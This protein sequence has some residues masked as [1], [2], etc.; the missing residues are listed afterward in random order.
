MG[1]AQG[2]LKEGLIAGLRYRIEELLGFGETG[3][4]YACR[5][6][7]GDKS[8]LVIKILSPI[9][10]VSERTE[11]LGREFALMRRLRHPN[12]VRILD[13]GIMENSRE[14]FLIEERVD[15]PD[16]YSG[17][18]GMDFDE[19]LFFCVEILKA[20]QYLHA[21][22]I[23]HGSL[24]PSNV[25]L[26]DVDAACR[27]PRLMDFNLRFR[28][29][30][31]C[32]QDGLR[33]LSYM[34]PE[35]LLGERAEKAS[36]IYAVGILIYQLLVRRLPFEDEDRGFLIQKQLQGNVDMKPFERLKAGGHLSLLI[37]RM[38][39]KDPM[40]RINSGNEVIAFLE[41]EIMPNFQNNEV[42]EL[43][44]HFSAAPLTGREMEMQAL[45][46]SVERVKE[47][48][49]GKTIFIVGEAGSGKTRCMEEL[50]SWALLEEWRV[51]EGACSVCEE[52]SYGPYLQVMDSIDPRPGEIIFPLDHS[53]RIA[54]SDPFDSSS[55]FAAG[56]FQDRLT[57]ELVRRVADR[58]TI[59]LLHDFHWADKATSAVLDFLSSDIQ[60]FPVLICVSLRPGGASKEILGR[61]MGQS[62][63]ND[64]GEIVSLKPLSKEN[65]HQLIAGMTG[66]GGLRDSFGD[67]IFRTVG[68]NPF[69]LEEMLKHFAEQGVLT[70][71]SGEWGF[72]EQ[73][74]TN[75]DV[76]PEIGAILQKRMSHLSPD[77]RFMGNWLSLFHRATTR[78]ILSSA[79][80]LKLE[81][82][83]E[84]LMELVQRQMVRIETTQ[85]D[86][87]IDFSHDL[88]SEVFRHGLSSKLSQRMHSKIAETIEREYEGEGHLNELAM[89]YIEGTPNARSVR[90]ALA[91]AARY[92][93]EYS[94]ENALRCF[95]H[96][97]QYGNDLAT[98]ELCAAAI[99]ASD[100]MFAIGRAKQAAQLL[101]AVMRTCNSIEPELQA[102][103]Y[104]QLALSYQYIGDFTQQE[105]YCHKG[106]KILQ[107]H[108]ISGPN[109]THAMLWA[110][111]AFGYMIQSRPQQGLRC[112]AKAQKACPERDAVALQGR[113]QSLYA[114]LYRVNCDLHKALV[115]SEKAANILN[116]SEE[117]Y[118]SCSAYS[119]LGFILMGL[120]RFQ[121]AL[122]KHQQ[123]VLLSEKNRS[124]ILK[125]Q[126]LGNLA[127][128]L[129]RRGRIQEALNAIA[130]ALKSVDES[131][132]PTIRHGCDTILAEIQF[133]AGDYRGALQ[134]IEP[135][136]QKDA[137]L[138]LF[139][140]GHALHIAAELFFYLGKFSE[141]LKYVEQLSSRIQPDAPFYEY[142]L[143]QA[144]RARIILE[145]EST[146]KAIDQLQDLDRTVAK[147]HWPYHRALIKIHICEALISQEKR[148]EAERYAKDALKLANAMNSTALKCHGNLLLGLI[149]SPVRHLGLSSKSG[150]CFQTS[151]NT[152]AEAVQAIEALLSCC[153]HADFPCPSDLQWRAQAELG[154]IYRLLGNFDSSFQ[155]AQKAYNCLCKLEDQIPSDLLASFY[156]VFNR[157]LVKLE[158]VKLIDAGRR[159]AH[160]KE[161]PLSEGDNARI[162]LRMSASINS[163]TELSPLLE[164]ILDQ[165]LSATSMERGFVFL[166]DEGTGTLALTKGRNSGQKNLFQEETVPREIL[167]LVFRE[168]AP[169]VS[170]NVLGDIRFKSE[171]SAKNRVGKLFC[172]A[173]KVSDRVIGVLYADHS[174][175]AESINATS[176]DIFAASCNLTVIAID[177]ILTR[178]RLASDHQDEIRSPAVSRDRYP[179][180]IG[181]SAQVE[182]LK[183]RISLAAASPLDILITG[184]SGTGKELVARA[185][186]GT[187]RR[188]QGKFIPVDCGSL[189]DSL[190]EAEL[191][192]YRKGAFTGAVESRQGLLEAADGGII[193]LD[194][195]SNMPLRLQAKLLRV[196][197]ER[198]V[199]RL[200]ETAP[201]KLDIQVIAAT[202]RDLMEEIKCDQFRGDLYYRLKSMEIR[203]PS[204][205]ERSEDI[206]LLIEWFLEKTA[207]IEGGRKKYI[208]PETMQLLLNYSYPGNI[209]ELRHIIASAYYSTPGSLIGRAVLPPEV[210]HK[211]A[212][213]TPS[214]AAIAEKIYRE[215]LEGKNGF[216][217][218]I[219]APFLKRQFG[220]SVLQEIIRK[221]LRDTSGV[222]RAALKRLQVPH[223]S[224]SVTIQFLKRHRC[225]LDFRPFRHKSLSS[226]LEKLL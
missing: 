115:A 169:V 207:E 205:R 155:Y 201:R 58:P 105:S 15:G 189:S 191:F 192:G 26:S 165:L 202:N 68:G 46:N 60:A 65:I 5:D 79:M 97:F 117:S 161:S 86:E 120:G 196:L 34:A 69:F 45:R 119:T 88:I 39:E 167:E 1:A 112:L 174:I 100:S 57:R 77:A 4:V 74:L 70:Y 180:I 181:K 172:G 219:K 212:D 183:E 24:K 131:N 35:I 84:P 138:T 159:Y 6:L 38:L 118:L 199:R 94:H 126:A 109:L 18:A 220:T 99:S 43:D 158:L 102:R 152:S 226:D 85:A 225:Y 10:A 198:E 182:A 107:H 163:S 157:S 145:R 143:A 162:L 64:R 221:S 50:R 36:D 137:N 168:G 215:V 141:S 188:R 222:Y 204:L 128:C 29:D 208:T 95:E 184:E 218:L 108:K 25:L 116:H 19:I 81:Q 67:R 130:C 160:S 53:P 14:L 17:T 72:L 147:K 63:H 156:G 166:R 87:T 75:L 52:S 59:I 142:E 92:R 175:P 210:F 171:C 140:K 12:L 32:R 134:T 16:L 8:K 61:V 80:S 27:R 211:D 93:D 23:V 104:M 148:K 28:L 62:I 216:D 55:G 151:V 106:I 101:D 76:P 154:F 200:G 206:A 42:N 30:R 213:E 176:I 98:E 122:E 186:S 187:G 195:I 144:L 133:A 185:I 127:E 217:D 177:N 48:G 150:N 136:V 139:T 170:A 31:S 203:L 44:C 113:I 73:K 21:R 82:I 11:I 78:T 111:L 153:E 3:D 89:H 110:E 22:G 37:H 125:A 41:S 173:L 54:E 33:T 179:E 49:R 178:R 7:G 129:C 51:V 71:K 209:R 193:F 194:E 146:L 103:M 164:R 135:L 40:K 197:Q 66:E 190:A 223:R 121:F 132:N 114:S 124:V 90:Y 123:A 13:F 83:E 91:S 149:H 20:L 214:D 96:V 224:Y 47:T 9:S 2:Q 56:Q